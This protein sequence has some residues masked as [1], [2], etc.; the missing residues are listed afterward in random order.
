M[1][2]LL[3]LYNKEGCELFARRLIDHKFD[4]LS[5]GGTAK[6]LKEKGIPVTDVAEVTGYP[7]VLGHRVV[8]LAP[9]VHGPLL[10]APEMRGELK[11]LGW[12]EIGLL[13]VTFYPLEKELN[14]P[15][16]TFA[17][18]IEK[19]DIGGPT[20]VRSANKGGNVIVLTDPDLERNVLDWL[21]RGMPD[22]EDFLYELRAAAEEAVYH[23][24][25]VSAR[26]YM[27]FAKA[28]Y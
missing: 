7:P 6:Y 9:Q 18:C 23:Y 4:I 24:V 27:R 28:A 21:D 2:A 20:M 5:S 13:Y 1:Y 15:K 3:S 25:A 14:D 22:R 17:S 26:V 11:S 8:T 19:T 10:A 16:A 12:P